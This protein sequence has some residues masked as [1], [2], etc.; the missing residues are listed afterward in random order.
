LRHGQRLLW[1]TIT[2]NLVELMGGKVGIDS[3]VG[4]GATF[5]IEFPEATP[6]Q[7]APAGAIASIES[8]AGIHFDPQV[9]THFQRCLTQILTIRANNMEPEV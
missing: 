7:H 5:W 2:R 4:C 8:Q 1:L 9:V 6:A 3:E